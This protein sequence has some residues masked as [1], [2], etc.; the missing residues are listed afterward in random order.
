VSLPYVKIQNGFS[1]KDSDTVPRKSPLYKIVVVL[2]MGVKC[3]KNA[4]HISIQWRQNSW[5]EDDS[6]V[7]TATG[8]DT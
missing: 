6:F 3:V 4:A 7:L 5:S 8:A 1:S 2:Q